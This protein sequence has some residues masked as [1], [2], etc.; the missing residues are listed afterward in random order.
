MLVVEEVAMVWKRID[1]VAV[2]CF[3]RTQ[4]SVCFASLCKK[5]GSQMQC[6]FTGVLLM[7][8]PMMVIKMPM[9]MSDPDV[10]MQ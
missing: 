4:S 7:A 8:L 1:L 6:F 2:S 9:W 10:G 5:Y 3:L